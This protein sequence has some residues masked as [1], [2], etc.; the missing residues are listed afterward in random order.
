[1]ANN[2]PEGFYEDTEREFG[3]D[4]EIQNDS[5]DF[6]LL[7][8]G[9]YDFEVVTYERARHPGSDK[10]PPCNKAVVHIRIQGEEGEITLK[11]NFFLHSKTE[12][13][14]CSF[15][16]SIGQREK[17]EKL[18]MNWPAVPG[19]KGRC[20]LGTKKY[21]P[22]GKTDE[23]TFNEIKRFYEPAEKPPTQHQPT[24]QAGTF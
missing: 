24:F 16:T 2:I 10:L 23:L 22:E 21:K 17:G 11:H 4:D 14:L 20:K 9:D 1:M 18:K 15:F 7:P 13:I 12:G 6:V 5:P 3:W 8:E 19:S